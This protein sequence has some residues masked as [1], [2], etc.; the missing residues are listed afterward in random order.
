MKEEIARDLSNEL[1]EVSEAA[2][3][4]TI[5]RDGFPETKAMLN[6]R[7]VK[8]YPGLKEVFQQHRDNFLI[9]FTTNLSSPK[10]ER[11]KENPKVCVYYCKPDEWMGL[12][13]AGS[14]EIIDD[15]D[16]KK[17]LWQDEWTMY[18]PNGVE[19]TDYTILCLKPT[20]LKGYHQLQQ[21]NIK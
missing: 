8:K 1:M 4:T 5:D 19:D 11:I 17:E 21:Y 2:Y 7:N 14:M 13:I 16:I 10:I 15:M 20:Y 9:Y 6:L 12:I 3:L 18:Y